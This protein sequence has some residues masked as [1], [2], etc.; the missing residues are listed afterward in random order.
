MIEDRGHAARDS[1][2]RHWRRE[3]RGTLK[4][5]RKPAPSLLSDLF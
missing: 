5:H 3:R 4:G 1:C 2:A